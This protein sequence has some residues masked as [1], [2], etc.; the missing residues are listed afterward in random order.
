MKSNQLISLDKNKNVMLH[1]QM[2]FQ[3][4]RHTFL[5]RAQM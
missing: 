2:Y 5:N 1:I 3:T 4:G